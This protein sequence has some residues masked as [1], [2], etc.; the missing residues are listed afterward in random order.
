MS[1]T[2]ILNW[3][4]FLGIL[5]IFASAEAQDVRT[6]EVLP[7]IYTVVSSS[8]ESANS[9]FI[10]T[11]EGVIIID[12][13]KVKGDSKGLKA[14]I[15]EITQ[16]PAV[17]LMNSHFHT[18]NLS[19]NSEFPDTKIIVAHSKTQKTLLNL[20]AAKKI[21]ARV[22]NVIFQTGM[23]VALG[24]YQLQLKHHGPGH[25][26]G[27]FYV[28]L[29]SWR[30]IITGGLVYNEIIPDL[31]DAYID[32]WID[33]LIEMEDLDAE[34]IVPGHGKPGN[35][36]LV[37]QTKHYLMRLRDWV[38]EGLDKGLKLP[39]IIETTKQNIQKKYGDWANQDRI[40]DNIIR[41]FLEYSAKKG[42]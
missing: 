18:E 19:G 6:R 22:P 14:R 10:V 42:T 26:Q 1:K 13:S 15:Q 33:T 25:T 38:K 20:L 23:E 35:K 8:T 29:P 41:A 37:T 39:K 36:P 34:I 4:I 28:Y 2:G 32:L 3:G 16:Q 7:N 5:L 24:G 21:E 9:T 31:K 11:K 27:D 17:Y 40:E 12:P 30:I